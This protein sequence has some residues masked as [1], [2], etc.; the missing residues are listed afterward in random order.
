MGELMSKEAQYLARGTKNQGLD[1]TLTL[2]LLLSFQ[3]LG[4]VAAQTLALP[5]PGPVLGM[6]GLVVTFIV[7]PSLA[8]RMADTA[9]GL[10]AHLSLLFVPAG[11]GVIT[12]LDLLADH[13]I[14]LIAA[15]VLSTLAAMFVAVF[16][17]VAVARL[18]GS[19]AET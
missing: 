5:L 4:E 8:T 9:N 10:L 13:G 17:F 12:H 2:A 3:L 6:A 16:T 19:E 14:A 18:V 15:L 11:V 7:F 1:M